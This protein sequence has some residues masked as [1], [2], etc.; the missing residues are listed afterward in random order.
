[1]AEFAVFVAK[2]KGSFSKDALLSFKSANQAKFGQ[3][4]AGLLDGL[5]PKVTLQLTPAQNGTYLPLPSTRGERANRWAA[6]NG[7]Q[8]ADLDF[9]KVAKFIELL[10]GLERIFDPSKTGAFEIPEERRPD[11]NLRFDFATDKF[12]EDHICD[13]SKTT[14][15]EMQAE[16]QRVAKRRMTTAAQGPVQPR[17]QAPLAFTNITTSSTLD[18]HQDK[19]RGLLKD[20]ITSRQKEFEAIYQYLI[21]TGVRQQTLL[22]GDHEEVIYTTK[23]KFDFYECVR[24]ANPTDDPPVTKYAKSFLR[25]AVQKVNDDWLLHHMAGRAVVGQEANPPNNNYTAFNYA[26]VANITTVRGTFTRTG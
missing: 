22:Q 16:A 24:A 20:E 18:L 19:M 17:G 2:Q 3:Q 8:Q 23:D 5:D 1:M 10:E 9:G 12:A 21:S 25:Y 6:M 13:I 7:K 4:L 11:Q 15:P 26:N 14:G